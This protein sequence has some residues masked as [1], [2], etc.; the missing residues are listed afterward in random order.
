VI[1]SKRERYMVTLASAALALFAFDRYA[2]S[3]FLTS[4]ARQKAEKQSMLDEKQ[5]AETLLKRRD[6]MASKW[7]DMIAGGLKTDATAAESQVFHAMREWSQEARLAFSSI[8]PERS[9]EGGD[10]REIEFQAAGT[11]SMRAVA[12]FLWR[13]ETA[14][15]PLRIKELQIGSRREGT[16]DL[17]LQLRLSTIYLADEEPPAAGA[18]LQRARGGNSS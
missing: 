8:K 9:T 4:R 6:M 11:G 18:G 1:L 17:S 2:L 16:D 3:P 14:S 5:L 7:N 12:Q 13:I 10:L 15:F